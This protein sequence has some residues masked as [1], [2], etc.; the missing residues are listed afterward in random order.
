M[1]LRLAIAGAARPALAILS[2]AIGLALAA[3]PARAATTSARALGMGNAY[4]VVAIEADMA[5]WNPALLGISRPG[6]PVFAVQLPSANL[7][8]GN[9][10]LS[11]DA[12]NGL[13]PDDSGNSRTFGDATMET[14]V[15]S[16][17]DRGWELL[18]VDSGARLFA[19]AIPPLRTSLHAQADVDFQGLGLPRGL[20]ELLLQGNTEQRNI[21]LDGLKGA[22]AAVVASAGLSHAVPLPMFSERPSAIGATFRYLHGLGW[23]NVEDA[24]GSILTVDPEGRISADAGLRY[25]LT[26]PGDWIRTGN[27]LAWDLGLATQ[28]NEALTWGLTVGNLGYIKW[29]K[30]SDKVTTAKISPRSLGLSYEAKPDGSEQT[31]GTPQDPFKDAFKDSVGPADGKSDIDGRLPPYARLGFAWRGALGL[32]PISRSP[33][34][35]NTPPLP[36]LVAA[37]IVQGFGNGYG[38]S[39]TPELHVGAEARPLFPMMPLRVGFSFG[40]RSMVSMGAGLDLSFYKLDLAFGTMNGVFGNTKGVYAA[41]TSNLAF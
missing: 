19:L 6:T 28:W 5:A 14:L 41:L 15:G 18:A 8:M 36:I 25:L 4:G 34:A 11:L 31:Q 1:N 33:L 27:G 38:V 37:D 12:L 10:F 24:S 21:N 22:S 35:F 9:N 7:G 13:L 23:L 39:T 30:V 16:M 26:Y 32:P 29:N 3:A 2:G 40:A 20:V 17:S